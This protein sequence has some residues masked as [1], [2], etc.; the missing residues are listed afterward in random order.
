MNK[1]LLEQ[2]IAELQKKL[3]EKQKALATIPDKWEPKGGKF[4][5]HGNGYI[6][7]GIVSSGSYR[8]FG[9]EYATREQAN[10]A[11]KRMRVH[12]ILL[13][14]VLEAAP[15]WEPDWDDP[16]TAK[17]KIIFDG[18]IKSWKLDAN[19]MDNVLGAVYMPRCVAEE[20]VRKL[21]DGEVEL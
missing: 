7:I 9:T 6:E 3:E 21:N 4:G 20:L 1:K 18:R 16:D 5:I 10:K 8:K 14:Y 11:V 13:A 12:N 2:E 19:Y 15:D 17:C